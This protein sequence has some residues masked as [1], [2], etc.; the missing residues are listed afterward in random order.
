MAAATAAM[1]FTE[2]FSSTIFEKSASRFPVAFFTKPLDDYE[3][4][5]M[6]ETLLQAGVDGMDLAVRPK[7]RVEPNTE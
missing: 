3:L 2:T 7:G 5:F 4:G 6:I 1:P